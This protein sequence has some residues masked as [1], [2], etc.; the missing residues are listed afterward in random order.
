MPARA[1]MLSPLLRELP[2]C[3]VDEGDDSEVGVETVWDV[4]KETI[5]V[6]A[7]AGLAAELLADVTAGSARD[8]CEGD[9]AEK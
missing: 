9:T 8:H 5:E 2:L 3:C 1:P 4:A 6:D 7:D